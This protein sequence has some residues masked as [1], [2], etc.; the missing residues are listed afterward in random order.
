MTKPPSHVGNFTYP[1]EAIKI[2]NPS[3]NHSVVAIFVLLSPDGGV[4]PKR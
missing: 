4:T 1:V 2:E 3:E